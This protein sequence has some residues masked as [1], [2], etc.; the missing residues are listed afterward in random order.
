MSPVSGSRPALKVLFAAPEVAPLAKTGGLADVAG[1]LPPALAG[2]GLEV[3]VI[4]PYYRQVQAPAR[5]TGLRVTV[6]LGLEEA[7]AELWET[8]LG[9]CPVYLVKNSDFFDRPGLYGERGGDYPDNAKRFSFFCRAVMEAARALDFAADILHL[10][11]WQTGL[12]A[13]YLAHPPGE[14]GPLAGARSV[15]TIH[16]IAYQGMF[17][18]HQ[19]AYTGL[20][21]LADTPEGIEYWGNISL[22]KAG[23][24][25]SH[26]ITTVSPTYAEEILSPQGG[27]G[28]EGLLLKRRGVLT[29]ILNGADYEQ[30][31]PARDPLLPANY[32]AGNLA[33]K[34]QCRRHLLEE[35]GLDPAGPQEAVLGFVGRLVPQKGIDLIAQAAP[36]LLLDPVRLC[37]L[38]TGDADQEAQLTALAGRYPGRVGVKLAFSE[39]LAHL[40]QAGSDM[41]LMPSRFEPCG[42]NQLYAMRYGTPPVAHATGG[43]KDTV[44]PFDPLSGQ[45]VGFVLERAQASD[46]LCAARSGLWTRAH[47][48]LWDQVRA[49]GMTRDHSW[50]MS[51]QAYAALYQ[52]LARS[53]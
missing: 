18:R 28:M 16:N 7:T 49:N 44:E 3:R 42:L 29:G 30:W 8:R 13:A 39:K 37:F 11:D 46:L 36:Y 48:Q 15:F 12:L 2:L 47:P 45:G 17:P 31:D 40:I 26:A 38:G 9:P 20:P 43:L 4:M 19:F 51:A 25:Y 52:R 24:N 35:F 53:G 50:S 1:A 23:L 21:F 34:R 27:R 10:H 6:P 32:S 41:L 22:L 14:P 5:D 33:G